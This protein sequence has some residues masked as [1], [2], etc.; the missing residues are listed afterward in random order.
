MN[1]QNRIDQHTQD[2]LNG[3]IDG[4]LSAVEQ[5]ELDE[6]IAGSE[7][8]RVLHGELE[9]LVGVLNAVPDR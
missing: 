7:N 6:M 4:E 5:A 8:V 2:L 9:E 3:S 1:E